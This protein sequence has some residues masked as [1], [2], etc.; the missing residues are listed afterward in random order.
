M[1]RRTRMMYE[2]RVLYLTE[3]ECYTSQVGKVDVVPS[4]IVI[5]STGANNP[6]LRRYIAPDDGVIGK[7]KYGNH[8]NRGG[9]EKCVH[10]MVGKDK[11]GNVCGYLLLPLNVCAWG[12]GNGKKGSYNYDPMYLQIEVCEDDLSDEEYYRSATDIVKEMCVG[13][14]KKFD[15]PTGNIVSHREAHLL[16]YASNHRDIDHWMKKFGDDMDKFRADI[17]KMLEACDDD[18]QDDKSPDFASEIGDVIEK[19]LKIREKLSDIEKTE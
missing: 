8:W 16:G 2:P 15:I 19:L 17:E 7:N 6:Y 4:G 11:D 10:A 5:H 9:V 12:V 13:F 1:K 3:N 14:C 18:E